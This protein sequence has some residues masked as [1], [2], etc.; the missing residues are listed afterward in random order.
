MHEIEAGRK[1][2]GAETADRTIYRVYGTTVA[3]KLAATRRCRTAQRCTYFSSM[4][5]NRVLRTQFGSEKI[6][7][8]HSSNDLI[9]SR[10]NI[11]VCRTVT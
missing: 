1:P 3:V 7:E 5:G 10:V 9:S 4:G 11:L 6:G 2:A 8:M